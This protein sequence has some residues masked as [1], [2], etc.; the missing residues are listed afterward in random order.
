MTQKKININ[1]LPSFDAAQYLDKD[2]AVQSI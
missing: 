1:D 2:Q